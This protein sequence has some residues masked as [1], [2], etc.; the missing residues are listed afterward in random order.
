M[1]SLKPLTINNIS[2]MKSSKFILP[3]LILISSASFAQ[4]PKYSNEFLSIGVGGRGLGMS[5][6]QSASVNDASAAFWNPAGL[7]LVKGSVQAMGMHS[8]YFAGIAKYEYLGLVAKVDATRALAFS[9]I[10]FAVD[11][12]PDTTEL[13]DASGNIDYDKLKSF[14]A[15]D[16]AFLLSYALQS[17]IAGLRYGGSVKVVHRTAGDF[18][19]SWGFGLDLGAQYE[20][21]HWQFGLMGKDITTTF[22]SWTFNTDKLAGVFSTTENEIPKNSTELTLPKLILGLGYKVNIAKKFTV[23]P[24]LDVDMT[25]DGQRNVVISGNPVSADPHLGFEIGYDDFIF[26]RGGVNNIQQ[27]KDQEGAK[28]TIFQPNMGIGLRL[29]NLTIDYA[30]T[31]IGSQE[32]LY[33]HV[34]SLKLD[35]YKHKTTTEK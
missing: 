22:N 34:F 26:L 30:L 12:I 7:S 24:E 14:S 29:K 5:N 19:H 35:I 9:F 3:V 2:P 1:V 15:A 16:Y 21:N 23:L 28:S 10:R 32:T 4:A 20:K 18:A 13:I 6:A 11:D 31:N 25:F 27:V 33:S 8:E 17:K